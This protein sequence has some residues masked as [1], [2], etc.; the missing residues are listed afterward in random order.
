MPAT[1]RGLFFISLATLM[2]EI[3][4]TRLFSATMFYH[5]TFTVLSLAMYGLAVGANLVYLF[6]RW[7]SEERTASHLSLFSTLFALSSTGSVIVYLWLLSNVIDHTP[8]NLMVPLIALFYLTYAFPFVCAGTCTCLALTRFKEQTGKLY[9]ADLLGAATACLLIIGLLFTIDAPSAVLINSGLS[10][11]AGFCFALQSKSKKLKVVAASTAALFAICACVNLY[12]FAQSK[13]VFGLEKIMPKLHYQKWTPMSF[14][15]VQPGSNVP[16]GWSID[17]ELCK[18]VSGPN[19]TLMMDKYAGTPLYKF[20][21]DFSKVEYIK[22]DISNLVH[23]IRSDGSIFVIGIGGG[24]D[25]LGSLL[26][27]HKSIVGAEFNNAILDVDRIHFADYTGHL[28]RFPGVEMFNEEA[29]SFL[30]HAGRNF[31]VIQASLIDTFVASSGGGLALTENSIYTADGWKLFFSHLTENGVLSFTYPYSTEDPSLA[32]RFCCMACDVLEDAGINDIRKHLVLI[33]TR[34]AFVNQAWPNSQATILVGKK[35]FTLEELEKLKQSA[36]RTHHEVILSPE[37]CIDQGFISIIDR[38]QRDEFIRNYWADISAPTDD[39]PF[40]LC[41]GKLSNY[42][43]L[44]LQTQDSSQSHGKVNDLFD[45]WPLLLGLLGIVG[46]F[47]FL[48]ILL[49]LAARLSPKELMKASDLLIFFS[50]IGAGFMFI[51]ISQMNR[52]SI[53]LGHPVFGLSVILFTL[54]VAS[55]LGSL[56]L[57]NK[58]GKRD[59][60]RLVLIIVALVIVGLT[61]PLLTASTAGAPILIRILVSVMVLG[62]PAFLMGM[63]LPLGM[64]ASNNRSPHL[65]PWLWGMNGATSVLGSILATMVALVYGIQATFWVGTLCYCVCLISFLVVTKKT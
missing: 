46:L 36:Q 30:T 52:L 24:K 2:F 27:R 34:K 39:H 5:F 7:F 55:G 16:W 28:D 53:Y 49:P 8:P 31:D 29:R 21:G 59:W 37:T 51:E 13:P 64:H 48:G 47:T 56:T 23:S 12:T 63:A 60:I 22:L 14:V 61:M 15:T 44:N 62:I 26:F 35:P 10:A 11:I 4:L 65:A 45:P 19:L 50:S 18:N 9:A 6:P 38:K 17:P 41:M 25:I 1:Y 32:Y 57:S 54:L 3:L 42:F 43:N 58:I 20:D 40:F 33:G